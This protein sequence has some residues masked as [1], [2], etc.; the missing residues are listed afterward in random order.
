[1][2][3]TIRKFTTALIFAIFYCASTFLQAQDQKHVVYITRTGEKYHTSTCQYLRQSKIEIELAKAKERGYSACSVCKPDADTTND[4]F[5]SPNPAGVPSEK[6]KGDQT[7]TSR[8]CL[9]TTAAGQRCKR[10]TTNAS[11]KCYQHE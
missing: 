4:G 5:T 3:V 10:K 7:T 2:A 8:Q 1:M 9:G 11:G 6:V